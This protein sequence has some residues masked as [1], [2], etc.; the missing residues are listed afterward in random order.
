VGTATVLANSG[1]GMVAVM[2]YF[3]YY[4]FLFVLPLIIVL[5]V[6]WRGKRIVE[7]K[8]WE[9]RAERWMKLSLGTLLMLVAGWLLLT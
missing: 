9:H 4:N 7:I 6:V 3:L 2:G 1:L 8:E 5:I